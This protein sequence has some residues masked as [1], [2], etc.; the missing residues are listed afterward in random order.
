M[1]CVGASP[2]VSPTPHPPTRPL[3]PS[4]LTVCRHFT[5]KEEL[6][7]HFLRGGAYEGRAFRFTCP[8]VP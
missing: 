2:K 1:Q 5:T 6:W 8:Y 3:R 4:L 7:S